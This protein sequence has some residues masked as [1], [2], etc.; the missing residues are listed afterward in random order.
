MPR[1]CGVRRTRSSST[2]S[3]SPGRARSRRRG[4]SSG[5]DRSFRRRGRSSGRDRSIRAP[6]SRTP[7][8]KENA[9]NRLSRAPEADPLYARPAAE[10]PSYATG[11][12][13]DA[14]DF[15]DEQTYHRGRLARALAS[16]TGGG[17][18]AGLRVSHSPATGGPSPRPEEIRVEPGLAVDRLGRLDRS[19]AA[20]VPPPAGVVRR[21]G[22][23]R[24]RR[25]PAPRRLPEPRPLPLGTR[26]GGSRHRMACRRCRRA[27]WWQTCSCGSSPAPAA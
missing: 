26:D 14:Q 22:R 20:G 2:C 24:R 6:R 1:D 21:R 9:M 19:A 18:L 3:G 5:R 17:T 12:L 8:K 27:A 25:P 11:M 7:R 16:L 4:R 23:G 15:T 10:R 13:L